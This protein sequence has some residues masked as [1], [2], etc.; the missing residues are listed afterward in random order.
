MA[1]DFANAVELGKARHAGSGRGKKTADNISGFSHGTQ[2]AYI[3][4]RLK[5]DGQTEIYREECGTRETFSPG[6]F[7]SFPSSQSSTATG[8]S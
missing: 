7:G 6:L 8:V 3:R 5:R 2:A 4:A 1:V